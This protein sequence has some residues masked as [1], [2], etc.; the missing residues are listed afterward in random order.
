MYEILKT[1]LV[2]AV[3]IRQLYKHK[4]IISFASGVNLYQ[5]YIYVH[6]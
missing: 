6:M 1:S 3:H 4:T 5:A 2:I